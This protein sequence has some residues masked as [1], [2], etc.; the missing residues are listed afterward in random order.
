M[1]REMVAR[2]MILAAKEL[3]SADRQIG[4]NHSVWGPDGSD[5]FTNMS[6]AWLM[7]SPQTWSLTMLVQDSE[8]EASEQKW[9]K[10]SV[11][12][13]SVGALNS[14]DL[15]KIKSILKKHQPT[16]RKSK[17]GFPFESKWTNAKGGGN[18]VNELI[19]DQLKKAQAPLDKIRKMI[20]KKL[21]GM[22]PIELNNVAK[23]IL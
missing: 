5:G 7:L 17:D 10:G 4:F 16:D 14:P 18:T 19:S 11:S 9:N 13:Y 15:G 6:Q 20:V 8:K 22:G 1:D 12:Q 2:E 23:A 21:D 3:T